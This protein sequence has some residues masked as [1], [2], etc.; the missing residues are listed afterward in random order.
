VFLHHFFQVGNHLFLIG[1]LKLVEDNPGNE[2][3]GRTGHQNHD[4][5]HVS[6]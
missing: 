2:K 4:Q 1:Y 3:E 5:E 6:L